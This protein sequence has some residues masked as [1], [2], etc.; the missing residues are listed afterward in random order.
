[1]N[2]EKLPVRID[3]S[4]TCSKNHFSAWVTLH[5]RCNIVDG[6]PM[7]YP[8]RLGFS[9]VLHDFGQTDP[10]W[11]MSAMSS[12]R[13]T[14]NG[15]MSHNDDVSIS[16]E[17]LT[18]V[19]MDRSSSFIVLDAIGLLLGPGNDGARQQSNSRNA[20]QY[21][22][23]TITARCL[24]NATPMMRRPRPIPLPELSLSIISLHHPGRL[25]PTLS[26][27]SGRDSPN[28][29]RRRR[30]EGAELT[31]RSVCRPQGFGNGFRE[32]DRG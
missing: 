6:G 22:Q 15:E 7:N 11:E 29:I 18:F 24:W 23:G 1:M 28:M 27:G 10:A 20:Q 31:N 9:V 26:A 32:A 19:I 4:T 13:P 5:E 21:P 2:T 16:I 25:R 12:I 3:G 8:F 17:R 14:P 30:L